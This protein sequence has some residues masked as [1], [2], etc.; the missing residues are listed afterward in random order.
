MAIQSQTQLS[1]LEDI[2]RGM[3]SVVVAYSGGVD[4]TLVAVAAHRVLSQRALAVTAVSP[5]LADRELKEATELARRF[6][7]A[8]RIVHTNEMEREGLRSQLA[9]ALLLLQDRAI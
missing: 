6:S 2:L 7:F 4:S 5:A 9:A 3:E 8:H 1:I